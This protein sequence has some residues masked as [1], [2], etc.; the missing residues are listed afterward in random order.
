MSGGVAG[1]DLQEGLAQYSEGRRMAQI[2]GPADRKRLED[3]RR[4]QWNPAARSVVSFYIES[5]AFAEGLVRS[6]G[7]GM[8][9]NLLKAMKE[10]RS[11]DSA[12]RKVFFKSHD[13][14]KQE[15]STGL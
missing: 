15:V 1:R 6:R 14:L 11:E 7:Q 12:Y 2:V 10:T 3:E 4:A 5:L 9:N 13:A 8:V